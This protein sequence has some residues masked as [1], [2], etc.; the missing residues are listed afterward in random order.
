VR[1]GGR[2]RRI[3]LD[4]MALLPPEVTDALTNAQLVVEELPPPP[5]PGED[6][7]ALAVFEPRE[8]GG[9]VVVYRRPLEARALNRAELTELVRLAVGREVILT[10]GLDVDLDEDW[11]EPEE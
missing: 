9:R 8:G 2:F 3:A 7:V 1:D 11:D 6:V 4:G 10:L 5:P